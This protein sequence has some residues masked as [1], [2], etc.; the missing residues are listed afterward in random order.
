[1]SLG[2]AIVAAAV[3]RIDK[4]SVYTEEPAPRNIYV[5]RLF[6]VHDIV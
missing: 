1:M 6:N 2:L 3:G 4:F 5:G